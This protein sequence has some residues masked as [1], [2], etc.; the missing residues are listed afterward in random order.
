M[1]HSSGGLFLVHGVAIGAFGAVALAL[2]IGGR[3]TPARWTAVLLMLGAMAHVFDNISRDLFGQAH[4]VMPTWMLSCA[5]S[6]LFWSFVQASFDDRPHPVWRRLLP[7]CVVLAVAMLAASTQ[8]DVCRWLWLVYNGGVGALMGHAAWLLAK[9]WGGDLVEGRRRLRAP[10]LAATVLYILVVQL[11]DVASIFRVEFDPNNGAQG[12]VLVLLACGA[13][14]VLLRPD[15]ALLADAHVAPRVAPTVSSIDPAD[16]AL[17]QRLAKA[18]DE[19]EVWRREDLTI[20]ALAMH[21][22]TPEHRLRHLINTQMGH[23]NF[24]AFIN[25]KRIEAAKLALAAPANGRKT[26]SAIAFDL[27]FASLG[28]FNRAFKEATGKTPTEWRAHALAQGDSAA[29]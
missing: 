15:S 9:G 11:A 5:A 3:A 19:E 27:G 29:A 14:L 8:G 22:Q 20:G 10:I 24:A 16:R 13:A 23:R 7:A 4:H 28:P 1:I 17:A 18:M 2:A 26:V 25:A 12:I 6:G 21:L